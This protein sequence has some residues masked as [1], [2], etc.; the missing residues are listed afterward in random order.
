MKLYLDDRVTR[1]ILNQKRDEFTASDAE[2]IAGPLHA[3]DLSQCL[4]KTVRTRRGD[5]PPL[6]SEAILRFSAGFAI[7]EWWLGSEA[8]GELIDGV[9]L[10]H[11]CSMGVR[12]ERANN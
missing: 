4:R 1:Y 12:K 3:S 10:Q 2:R 6:D 9:I 7:Q 11:G 5:R 8:D